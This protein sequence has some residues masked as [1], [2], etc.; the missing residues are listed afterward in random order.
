MPQVGN[1][2]FAYTED[3][4]KAATKEAKKQGVKVQH[5]T[6]SSKRKRAADQIAKE[7]GASAVS[8]LKKA[9]NRFSDDEREHTLAKTTKRRKGFPGA[10]T[11]TA[12]DRT[13][14]FDKKKGTK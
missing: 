8:G 6:E 14:A 9:P 5:A 7:R 1:K 13:T 2:H 3:G 11:L 12:M 10:Q 4:L